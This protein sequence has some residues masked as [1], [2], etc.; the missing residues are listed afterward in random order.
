MGVIKKIV[1]KLD[2]V[3]DKK[4]TTAIEQADVKPAPKPAPKAGDAKFVRGLGERIGFAGIVLAT[5]LAAGA[6][7][8]GCNEETGPGKPPPTAVATCEE[9]Q[10]WCWDC[11]TDGNRRCGNDDGAVQR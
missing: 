10:P 6:S 1:A 4:V 9:D 7:L 11:H 3:A 2:Q 8:A 5:V